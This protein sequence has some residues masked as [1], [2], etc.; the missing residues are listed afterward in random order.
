M[1]V[2]DLRWVFEKVVFLVV[3][4]DSLHCFH[5]L[6]CDYHSVNYT[7]M[8]VH[9]GSSQHCLYPKKNKSNRKQTLVPATA[10]QV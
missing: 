3:Y 4:L 2:L 1:F 8:P 7:Y 9:S 6:L 5:H 10:Q